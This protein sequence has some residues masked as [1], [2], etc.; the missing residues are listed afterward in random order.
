MA[1]QKD[2]ISFDIETDFKARL[3]N[4]GWCR[5]NARDSGKNYFIWQLERNL[6]YPCGASEVYKG[7]LPIWRESKKTPLGQMLEELLKDTEGRIVTGWNIKAFDIRI[8]RAYFEKKLG[9]DWRP[10]Y[11]DGYVYMKKMIKKS[12]ELV[13]SLIKK[14]G[15]TASGK[16]PKM[17]AEAMFRFTTGCD[18]YAEYHTALYDA[19]DERLLIKLMIEE[20]GFNIQKE[21]RLY[22]P[23]TPKKKKVKK[24][25]K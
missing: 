20:F 4:I 1:R 16:F 13:E 24:E 2:W 5:S 10:T 18:G 22:V 6:W 3:L 19:Q 15:V 11:F 7:V 23:T 14:N 17:T 9:V 12:P 8:M 25:V 21:A